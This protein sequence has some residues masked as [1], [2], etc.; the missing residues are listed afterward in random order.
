MTLGY[1]F[2]KLS[3]K[4]AGILQNLLFKWSGSPTILFMNS[5]QTMYHDSD[6]DNHSALATLH[7]DVV[8]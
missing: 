8:T 2:I 3:V 7:K 1:Y 6:H 4:P 5:P